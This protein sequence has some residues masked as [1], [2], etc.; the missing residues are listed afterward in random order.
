[1]TF[2]DGVLAFDLAVAFKFFL[3]IGVAA[4]VGDGGGRLVGLVGRNVF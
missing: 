3:G 4:G 1:M 2:G